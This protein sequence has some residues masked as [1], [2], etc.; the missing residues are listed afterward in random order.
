MIVYWMSSDGC[1]ANWKIK[2]VS[3]S[4]LCL[5]LSFWYYYVLAVKCAIDYINNYAEYDKI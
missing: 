3:S 1:Y 4:L 2:D 5:F